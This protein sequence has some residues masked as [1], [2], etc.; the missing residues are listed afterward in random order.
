[1]ILVALEQVIDPELHKPVTELEMV[2]DV[3]IH[4]DGGVEVRTAEGKRFDARAVICALPFSTLRHV[5]FDPLLAGTQQRAVATL[6][7]QMIT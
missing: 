1:M 2:R 5:R 6:P 4:D 3:V 7:H